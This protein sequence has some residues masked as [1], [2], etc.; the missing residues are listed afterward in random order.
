ME[1]TGC[2]TEVYSRITGFFGAGGVKNWNPGKKEE[3][4]DREKYN[5][6]KVPKQVLRSKVE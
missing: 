1:K 4:K 6:K 5:I 3:F 2:E